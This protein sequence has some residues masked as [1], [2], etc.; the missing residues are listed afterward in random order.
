[1]P[2]RPYARINQ[3]AGR[4]RRLECRLHYD[5]IGFDVCQQAVGSS[6]EGKSLFGL[7]E[8]LEPPHKIVVE[9]R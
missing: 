1:M 4:S 6:E 7:E 5:E 2:R 3:R 8:S 9:T